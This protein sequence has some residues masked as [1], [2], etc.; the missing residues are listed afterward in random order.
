MY[1]LRW[2]QDILLRLEQKYKTELDEFRKAYD[3]TWQDCVRIVATNQE[4]WRALKRI[5]KR[6]HK[7]GDA[8]RILADLRN[9][10]EH[11]YYT[12][13]RQNPKLPKS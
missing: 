7:F 5:V 1:D 11:Y 13:D 6:C 12:P 9:E 10:F 3:L 8:R 2:A 4:A